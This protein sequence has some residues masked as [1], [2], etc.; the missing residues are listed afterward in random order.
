MKG[1][2]AGGGHDDWIGIEDAAAYLAVP[3]RT[4]YRLAQRG[5][6]PASKVGRTW[7]FKRTILDDHLAT[8]TNRAGGEATA[9]GQAVSGGATADALRGDGP[10]RPTSSAS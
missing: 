1:T 9:R 7:R 3:V 10:P 2:A 6:V 8:V 5:Q 4:L